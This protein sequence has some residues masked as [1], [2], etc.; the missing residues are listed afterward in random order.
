MEVGWSGFGRAL[1]NPLLMEAGPC[2]LVTN[3]EFA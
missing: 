1:R 3:Q 2:R